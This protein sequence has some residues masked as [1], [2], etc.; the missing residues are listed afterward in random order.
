LKKLGTQV[1][2][3]RSNEIAKIAELEPSVK[4]IV[5]GEVEKEI[6]NKYFDK[7]VELQ[8]IDNLVK[9]DNGRTELEYTMINKNN[10]EIAKAE[11]KKPIIFNYKYDKN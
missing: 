8:N 10:I 9:T 6:S 1:V 7:I 4:Y 5:I 3:L 11:N 2:L